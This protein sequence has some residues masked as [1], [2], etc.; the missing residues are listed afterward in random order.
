MATIIVRQYQRAVRLV[1]GEA[2]EVLAP[3]RYRY[4]PPRTEILPVDLRSQ[5]LTVSGQ[6]VLTADGVAV[7]V[8]VVLRIAVSDPVTHL[9]VSQQPTDEVYTAAQHSVR[10]AVTELTL[11]ALLAARASLG[12]QLVP[13]VAAAGER[14]GLTVDQVSLRDVM[15]PGELRRAYAQ[16]VLAREQGRAELERARAETAAL[17]SMANSAKL[18]E[19]HPALLRLRTLQVAEQAGTELRLTVGD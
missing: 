16:T 8:T 17:R 6:E 7:R 15:L 2:R 4:R 11:E 10:A 5:L 18:L 12:P 14:V 9:T 3:G 1:D 19:Q 13:E